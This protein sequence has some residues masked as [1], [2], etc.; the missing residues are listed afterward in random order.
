MPQSSS[1]SHHHH[2]RRRRRRYHRSCRHHCRCLKAAF[3]TTVLKLDF[4]FCVKVNLTLVQMHIQANELT[5][6]G[7]IFYFCAFD[8]LSFCF[9][10]FIL[11][12]ELLFFLHIIAPSAFES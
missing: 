2:R 11:F 8:F 12:A 3:L 1:S 9:F 7:C 6:T 10:F 5:S 4:K